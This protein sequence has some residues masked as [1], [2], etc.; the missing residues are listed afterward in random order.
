[1][2]LQL[3]EKNFPLTF[4][5]MIFVTSWFLNTN[6]LKEVICKNNM[7]YVEKVSKNYKKIIFQEKNT[8]DDQFCEQYVLQ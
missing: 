1:M 3:L 6:D 2:F 4:L 5:C 8:V 7:E